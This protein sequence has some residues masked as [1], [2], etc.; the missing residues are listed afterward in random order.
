M[1]HALAGTADHVSQDSTGTQDLRTLVRI[2]W[3]WKLLLVAFVVL[4]PAAAYWVEHDKPRIYQSSTLI[5]LQSGATANGVPS[6]TGNLEAVAALVNTAPIARLAAHDLHDPPT[7]AG[8]LTHA[9]SASPNQVTGF[10][11]LTAQATSPTLAAR[12][13]AAFARAIGRYETRQ[14]IRNIDL[15]ILALNRQLEQIPANPAN[16]SSRA[17]VI[18]Q[19]AQLKA[20]RG[21]TGAGA[22]VL[23]P[24]AVDPQPVGP[25]TRRAVELALLIGLLAGIGASLIAESSDRRLRRAED[26][27]ELTGIGLVGSLPGSAFTARPFSV[28]R[29]EEAFQMLASSLTYFNIDRP[30]RSLAVAS[31]LPGDGKTTVAV[32][33]ALACARAGQHVALIDADL[34]RPRVCARLGIEE[35]AGLV[36]VLTGEANLQEH[37]VGVPGEAPEGGSLAILPAGA[38]HPNP[39]AL[40]GS[41][42]MREVLSKLERRFDLVVIDTSPALAVGDPLPLFGLVSGVVMIVRMNRSSAS[43]I[44]RLVKVISAARGTLVGVI[45]TGG[46]RSGAG[47][48]YEYGSGRGG[49]RGLGPLARLRRSGRRDR[50]P[51][52]MRRTEAKRV[53]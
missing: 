24:A 45:A 11:T 51:A 29:N 22:Q 48:G 41:S 21:A 43:V 6:T 14:Q 12:I 33:L 5:E 52:R 35:T 30:V 40:L 1:R 16:T 39:G 2:L 26:L 20:E 19:I 37:L 18:A 38:A 50:Q 8:S 49:R 53:A 47:Y 15:Q 44:R 7:Q 32:G 46:S 31:P 4:L 36:E 9:V 3:R 10:M 25:K 23:D 28:P 27:E 17:S 13:A 34:R 42:E